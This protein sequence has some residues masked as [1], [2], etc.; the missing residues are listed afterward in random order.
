MPFAAT[1]SLTRRRI[2]LAALA[3]LAPGRLQAGGR[4]AIVTILGDS[5]TAGY[6][7]RAED[8]LPAQLQAALRRLGSPAIVRG[9]G[10]SG[11]TTAGGLARADFSVQADT[12]VCVVALGGNDLL[13]GLDP[14]AMQGNLEHIVQNLKVRRIGVVLCGLHAP[15]GLSR[16]YARDFNAVF[17]AVARAQRVALYPDLLDGVEQVA[18]LN[19]A[20][21][22]HP[23]P[24]GVKLIAARLAPL[25]ARALKAPR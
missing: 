7:L 4:P 23:N 1:S 8:A 11:D 12:R 16:S 17:P 25:V 15:S 9:A 10:V 2:L 24:R 20:D 3:G 18:A 22:L 14:K 13:Q 19:Q 5:I 6:G 21:G